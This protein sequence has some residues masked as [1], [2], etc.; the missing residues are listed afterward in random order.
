MHLQG[1][2]T[3][4][5]GKD[6]IFHGKGIID[7]TNFEIASFDEPIGYLCGCDVYAFRNGQIK[8]FADGD[9]DDLLESL[10]VAE[11]IRVNGSVGDDD[12]EHMR[13]VSVVTESK[14]LRVSFFD[15]RDKA[16]FWH[17]VA[18]LYDQLRSDAV[19]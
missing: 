7:V 13:E 14:N 5:T 19:Q 11:M 17:A 3:K 2:E 8:I 1:R 10:S 6:V 16:G 18:V 4:L 12:P 15:D 9:P